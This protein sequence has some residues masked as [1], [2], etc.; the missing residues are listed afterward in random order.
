MAQTRKPRITEHHWFC[1]TQRTLAYSKS[2]DIKAIRPCRV[3]SV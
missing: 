2:T 3:H 1:L